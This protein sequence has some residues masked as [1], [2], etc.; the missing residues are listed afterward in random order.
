MQ[1]N[2]RLGNSYLLNLT[3][4]TEIVVDSNLQDIYNYSEAKYKIRFKDEFVSFSPETFITIENSRVSTFPM[5]GTLS[6]DVKNGE[7]ILKS[8]SKEVAEHTMVVDLLRNDLNMVGSNVRVE[9]FKYVEKIRSGDRELFQMSSKIVADLENNWQ[10][11]IGDILNKLLPAGSI[12]GTPKRKTV[13]L[14]EKIENYNRGFYTG[15]FGVFQNNSFY[16][17]VMIRFVEKSG[18]KLIYKSGGGITLDSDLDSEYQEMLEK[19]Y[20]W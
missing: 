10:S 3:Q 12:T 2:I 6:G 9:N 17:G 19:I 16:S 13:E 1:R 18:D 7:E 11:R 15:V 5:K 14:I 4:P 20:I 8:N